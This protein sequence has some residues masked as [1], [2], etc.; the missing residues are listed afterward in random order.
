VCIEI[1]GK[2]SLA[3]RQVSA[4]LCYALPQLC[5]WQRAESRRLWWR[6]G[7]PRYALHG[8]APIVPPASISPIWAALA[9]RLRRCLLASEIAA[10]LRLHMPVRLLRRCWRTNR[11]GPQPTALI[12]ESFGVD[13]ALPAAGLALRVAASARASALRLPLLL[14]LLLLLLLRACGYPPVGS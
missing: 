11:R 4:Q 14:L 10:E 3:H 6:C 7:V 13:A 9:T 5:L 2:R 1:L 12:P 8:L